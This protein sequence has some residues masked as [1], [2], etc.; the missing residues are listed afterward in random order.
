VA[1]WLLYIIVVM[2]WGST[3]LAIKFQL[4]DV[5]PLISLIYRF[6]L[7]SALLLIWCHLKK[8]SLKVPNHQHKYL[9]LQGFFLFGINYWLVYESELYISSGLVAVL[10]SSMVFFNI[11]NGRLF[12]KT[13]INLRV[14]V[15]ALIGC[16]GILLVFKPEISNFQTNNYAALGTLLGLG[17]AYFASVG[18]I[19]AARNG[20]SGMSTLVINTWSMTYGTGL[21]LLVALIMGLPFTFV[22]TPSYMGSLLYLATFGTVI[23]FGCYLELINRIG[24]DK[25]AYASLLFPVV[26]LILASVFEGYTWTL[27]ALIGLIIVIFGNYIALSKSAKK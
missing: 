10:F 19:A 24:A 23:S 3:Y 13:P 2:V 4:G 15:G 26:A 11:I 12:L 27:T 18:N 25:A 5:E 20:S 16:A 1:T 22:E 14:L 17:S 21:M 9:L 6:A 7:A 8:V